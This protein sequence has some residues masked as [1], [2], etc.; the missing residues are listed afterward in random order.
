MGPGASGP[1]RLTKTD[2]REGVSEDSPVPWGWPSLLPEHPRTACGPVWWP[3]PHCPAVVG[4]GLALGSGWCLP[5]SPRTGGSPPTGPP[6]CRRLRATPAPTGHRCHRTPPG[7]TWCVGRPVGGPSPGQ[8]PA[9]QHAPQPEA[10]GCPPPG[11]DVTGDGPCQRDLSTRCPL[12]A[13]GPRFACTVD[14][15][16]AALTPLTACPPEAARFPPTA[17]APPH[18]TAPEDR[19]GLQDG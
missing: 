2:G 12:S 18:V 9:L 19:W 8:P 14:G 6:P 16:A 10:R 3:L 7:R 5:T 15:K 11:E 1:V 13:P 17:G 4:T